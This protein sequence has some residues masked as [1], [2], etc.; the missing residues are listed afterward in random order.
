MSKGYAED[1]NGVLG[2]TSL[3]SDLLEHVLIGSLSKEDKIETVS[4]RDG[5]EGL[6][7]RGIG[8]GIDDR[9]SLGLNRTEG[10]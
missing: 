1:G 6:E 5:V 9:L 4:L 2:N 10:E 7:G 3:T 8:I